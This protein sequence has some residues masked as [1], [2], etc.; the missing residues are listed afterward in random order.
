MRVPGLTAGGMSF[1]SA[2]GEEGDSKGM[3]RAQAARNR[4]A[5]SR[6]SEREGLELRDSESGSGT[7]RREPDGKGQTGE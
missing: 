3:E 4:G 1:R 6:K 7:G 5:C 2:D